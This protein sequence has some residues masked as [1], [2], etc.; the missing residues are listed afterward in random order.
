MHPL[1]E[2]TK[3]QKLFAV[4]CD[5]STDSAV[6][7]KECICILFVEP[8]EFDLTLSFVALK[9]VPSQDA[10]RIKS[11]IMKALIIL[12]WL[13]WKTEWYF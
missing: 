12:T 4:F 11:A 7:E 8:F 13:N 1:S 3:K 6:I 2:Q 10:D 9:D 5:G